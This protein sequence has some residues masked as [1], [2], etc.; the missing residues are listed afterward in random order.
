MS[1]SFYFIG[2]AFFG[3]INGIFNQ[4]S[5]IFTLLYAQMLAG[6][7]LFGS[8]SLTLMFAS[9]MV[10]TATVILGGIPAAIYERVTGA[11]ESNSVSLWIWLAGTAILSLPAVGNFLKIGL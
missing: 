4:L 8:L 2:I 5:L 3:M 11:A 6:P 1:R 7:L 9:L 10:S